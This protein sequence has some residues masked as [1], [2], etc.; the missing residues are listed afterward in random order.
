MEPRFFGESENGNWTL[1]GPAVDFDLHSKVD[2]YSIAET[3]SEMSIFC[4][5]EH[6]PTTHETI[7]QLASLDEHANS[8]IQVVQRVFDRELL[9]Q[10]Q[11]L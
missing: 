4:S 3:Q 2:E 11:P 7:D 6:P 5:G 9:D 8:Y 10:E 1:L